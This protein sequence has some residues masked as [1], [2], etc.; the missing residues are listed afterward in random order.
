MTIS[1]NIPDADATQ[2]VDGICA[3]TNYDAGSGKTKAQWAKEQVVTQIK[4]L[5]KRGLWRT[6]QTNVNSTVDAV[7]IT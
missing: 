3:A 5:A 4:L 6:S 7:V 2:I 1:L